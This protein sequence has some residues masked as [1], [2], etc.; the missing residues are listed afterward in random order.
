MI[1]DALLKRF[2]EI[3]GSK[4]AL[5]SDEDLSRY[6]HENRDI[7]IGKTPLV[8]KPASAGEVSAIVRLASETGTAIVPQGGHTG[9]TGGAVPDE[10]GSQ[11]VVSLERLNRIR[12]IDTEGNTATVEAGVVLQNLQQAADAEDRL[13]PL[14]LGSQ[15]SCQIGGNISTN[16]GG[17]GVLAYGNT[18]ELVLGLEVV[19]PSGELW[20]GLRKLKKDNTGYSLKNLFIGAEGTLGIVTAAVVKLFP[21]PRGRIVVWAGLRSPVD[22]LAVLNAANAAAGPSLT[23]FELMHRTPLEFVLTANDARR[24]P[25]DTAHEWYVLAEISSG[26]SEEDA[27]LLAETTFGQALENDLVQD[28]VISSSERETA[29]LWQLREE[30]APAQV[31]QG[32]SI[33]HDISLPIASIP[34]FLEQAR[35]IIEA[36]LPGS[37]PCIFGHLGDGNLHYNISK[38]VD[39]DPAGFLAMRQRTYNNIHAL[40]MK[41]GGS[42]SAE[43]GI[44]RLKR[45]LLGQVK[46]PVELG[47]MHA[48]KRALDPKGIMN[49]GKVLPD[50][51]A[52]KSSN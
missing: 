35:T 15:G 40:V 37:R 50:S 7:Y 5:G 13:F 41:M 32:A 28:A 52:F 49:P 8:L 38:P 42:V 22:G 12:E 29:E 47:T 16:A 1:D 19:L 11:I 14:A 48:I 27:R 24:D 21:K 34:A 6:T 44:G 2:A 20:D 4:H 51:S 25:L 30:M 9:H 36:L 26:R 43:H 10:S 33:K 17:T 31:P 3:V 39:A 46:S 18:R 45:D 23:G